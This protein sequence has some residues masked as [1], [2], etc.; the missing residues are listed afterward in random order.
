MDWPTA[1]VL[2]ATVVA[3]MAVPT[4]YIAARNPRSKQDDREQGARNAGAREEIRNPCGCRRI[5]RV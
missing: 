1:A 2:I 3:L 5:P 4:T